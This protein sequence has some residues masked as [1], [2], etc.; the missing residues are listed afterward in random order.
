MSLLFAALVMVVAAYFWLRHQQRQLREHRRAG[1]S[2]LR[3]LQILLA[4]L[5]QHRGLANGYIHGEVALHRSLLE[6][7]DKVHSQITRIEA[8][9]DWV[10]DKA[11]WQSITESWARILAS[12]PQSDPDNSFR[13][14][15]ALIRNVLVL[16]GHTTERHKLPGVAAK[17]AMSYSFIWEKLLTTAEL[18]GQA[19]GLGIGIAVDGECPASA[20]K[21]LAKLVAEIERE[22]E[23]LAGS[24][25]NFEPV[26]PLV[27]EYLKTIDDKLLGSAP[28][29]EPMEYF[30][31]ASVAIDALYQYYNEAL[32]ELQ[33]QIYR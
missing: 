28:S 8:A 29:I 32:R 11:Y 24:L 6:V 2:A 25:P 4:S 10:V 18:M 21:Q 30:S 15:S 5:Q 1:I 7:R 31:V 14:H 9:S 20:R 17:N 16:I 27:E 12:F 33:V 13:T 26:T 23:Q 22:S 3:G 19:R